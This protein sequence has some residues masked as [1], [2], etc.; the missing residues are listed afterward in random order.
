MSTAI[1]DLQIPGSDVLIDVRDT[2]NLARHA[3]S[4]IG[5]E[6]Y[7]AAHITCRNFDAT[8]DAYLERCE[9]RLRTGCR[10]LEV[11]CGRSRLV[12]YSRSGL[13]L[14]LVDICETMLAHSLRFGARC[15]SP[16][17]GSAFRLP[18]REAAFDAAFAFLADPYMH[19]AYVTELYRVVAPGGR[20]VQIVPAYEW[21]APL[22][23]ERRSP[24]HFSH[25]FRGAREAFG[26][27]F[28]LQ[29]SDLVELVGSAGFRD[30]HLADLFLPSIVPVESISPDI[31]AP[32]DLRGCS[33]Y[34]LPLLTVVEAV[35]L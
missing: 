14:I 11:G 18:F 29:K 33:P 3:Y 20:I 5:A 13:H 15:A 27:S 12:R 21:G 8:L 28:L 35:R 2:E 10:Y 7:D 19:A 32:A 4:L 1:Q 25:F 9:P 30:I 31:S 22:R 6:Y 24:A 34:A 16:L 23:A 26:P 17:L